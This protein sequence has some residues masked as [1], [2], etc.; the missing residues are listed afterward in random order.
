MTLEE[1]L[2][3][4]RNLEQLN[5]SP[6]CFI[7]DVGSSSIEFRQFQS[8]IEE[9]VFK[10]L[11]EKKFNVVHMDKRTGNGIDLVAD[12]ENEKVLQKIGRK[13]DLIICTSLLEH[14]YSIERTIANIVTLAVEGGYLLIDVPHKWPKHNDPIDNMFRPTDKQLQD[15]FSRYAKFE[16]LASE[17]LD[18]RNKIHYFAKSKYPLWGYRKFRFWRYYFKTYRWKISCLLIKMI[19]KK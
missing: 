19:S 17:I 11:E 1:S 4:K 12:I 14:V 3:I 15:L 18:I 13:F 2:W 10:P 8:Y 5:L 7:L 6:G 16:V 9:N